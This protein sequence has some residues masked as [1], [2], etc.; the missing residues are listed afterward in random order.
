MLLTENQLD[1]FDRDGFILVE[2]LFDAEEMTTALND[3]EQIFYG[4]PY[5]AYLKKLDET[6]EVD[7][8]EPTVTNV[9]AH[10]GDTE[11]GR[12]QF[13]TG[14]DALDRLIENE[15]YLNVFAQCL[16]T[17]DVS[18]CNAHLFMRSGPTDERCPE[19]P[20]QGYH[21]DHGTNT[22]L[23]LSHAVGS[24]DYVNSGVYLHD[25]PDDCAPMQI[26]PGSHRQI[27]DLLPKLIRD[28]NW[29][30]RGGI[31]DIRK[32][33]EFADPV[34][35]TGKAGSVRFNSSFGVHA[36]IPFENKRRQRGYSTFSF[37][38]A[39]TSPWIKLSNLW[40]EQEYSVPFWKNTT[41]R[42]RSL[43]GWP[44]AG[45]PY[46]TFET[47]DLLSEWYPGIDLTSYQDKL[48]TEVAN[49]IDL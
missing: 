18:Y 45:H 8:V 19:H 13:P 48:Q 21:A 42:V 35:A 3:M 26:I 11:Y 20:W 10:Y 44:K 2:D 39:D 49:S 22:F 40:R 23:P 37:S 34:P 29:I 36:A 31:K 27:M 5:A 33:P 7:A 46:Y 30:G 24:F 4:K 28:G 38:R 9:V 41:P 1:E 17:D 25:V 12:A 47:L 16:G 43:F 15:A 6:G 14:F 32:V